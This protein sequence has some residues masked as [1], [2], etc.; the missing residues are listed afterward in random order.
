MDK[1]IV[2]GLIVVAGVGILYFL[3]RRNQQSKKVTAP[4]PKST[5]IPMASDTDA[6]AFMEILKDKGFIVRIGTEER[7]A[8]I[9]EYKKDVSK[10]DHTKVME[11]LKKD[12][13]KWSLEEEF[14]YQDKFV[15]NVLTLDNN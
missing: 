6:I 9:T 8:F 3:Y 13:S 5:P 2:T 7:K 14:F 11:L 10:A 1:K 15:D 12:P 4:T